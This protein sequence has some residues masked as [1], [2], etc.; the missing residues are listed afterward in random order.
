MSIPMIC[1]RQWPVLASVLVRF[2]ALSCAA[3]A[4][5]LVLATAVTA[6]ALPR[7]GTP[8]LTLGDQGAGIDPAI[9]LSTHVNV[10]VQG[11]VADA[12]LI[13]RF[14]NTHVEWVHGVY[15][16]PVP[17]RAAVYGWSVM[18]DGREIRGV[19][20]ERAE[21]RRTFEN[22]R[23]SGAQAGLVE[24]IDRSLLRIEIANIPPEAELTVHL[25]MT[26]P[27]D[28]DGDHLRLVMPTTVTPR[29][30]SSHAPIERH[31]TL[32]FWLEQR[33]WWQDLSSSPADVPLVFPRA[34][35]HPLTYRV[36]LQP[37]WG[38][39]TRVNTP[40][41]ASKGRRTGDIVLI[42]P[43]AESAEMDRDFIVEW[44]VAGGSGPQAGFLVQESADGWYG[45]L[46]MVAPSGQPTRHQPEPRDVILILDVSGS[47][48]GDA[49]EQM[50]AA[51]AH[52]LTLLRAQDSVNLVAFDHRLFAL[53]DQPLHATPDV[54][55]EARAFVDDLEAD[56]GTEMLPAL[57]W[58][59]DQ[60]REFAGGRR[61][62]VFMTDGAVSAPADLFALL[63][64]SL[65]DVRLSTVAMGS[66]PNTAFMRRAAMIGR[67]LFRQIPRQDGA[68]E[69]LTQM[70]RTLSQPVLS[71]I[72]VS[73]PAGVEPATPI[74]ADLYAGQPLIL[75]ARF[76]HAPMQGGVTVS[77]IFDGRPWQR[78][79]PMRRLSGSAEVLP[80][81]WARERIAYLLDEAELGRKSTDHVRAEVLELGLEH[82]L[83]TPYTSLVAVEMIRVR[84]PMLEA[85]R[86]VIPNQP[87]ATQFDFPA[88]ATPAALWL[89]LGLAASLIAC[90]I[91]AIGREADQS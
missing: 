30:R 43:L 39:I 25:K 16:A 51:A 38:S 68:L 54:I 45:S 78:E 5:A 29:Y 24:A 46:E 9:L 20:K 67:G 44:Q 71:D 28:V 47:M 60:V 22:A 90:F 49:I 40:L 63:N 18:L 41:H 27:V 65:G 72:H 13:Q 80:R 6:E 1:A 91:F 75:R 86:F 4:C 70:F 34:T 26:L 17:D 76:D 58:A 64:T 10:A 15:V 88:T 50:K 23:R 77:G 2:M 35:T 42:E 32:P 55:A 81:Q 73:W 8:Q 82:S 53:F 57:T 89:Y 69:A 31:A 52:A 19:V 33:A 14:R 59:L 85:G 61:E 79:L 84:S 7:P 87:P 37:S 83:V 11:T 48:A 62:L 74:P 36:A 3:F 56:G 21:A 12:V 66:A